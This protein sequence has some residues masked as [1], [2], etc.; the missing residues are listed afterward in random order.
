MHRRYLQ[1]WRVLILP[2]FLINIVCQYLLQDVRLCASSLT[3]LSSSPFVEVLLPSISRIVPSILQGGLLKFS[4]SSEIIK[5]KSSSLL[6]PGI[7]GV[8]FQY[9]Q[10]LVS[11]H[12]I[13]GSDSFMA[14][15][16]DICLSRFSLLALHIFLAKFQSLDGLHS[17]F[18]FQVL[19]SQYLSFG[20]CTECTNYHIYQL[21]RS[22]RIWYKVNF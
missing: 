1:C 10:I 5:K 12:F 9:S 18:Y 17:S 3:F 21:L 11:F 7:D 13:E 20:L 16:S 6:S 8:F 4:R 19:Q 14:I 2:F 15:A 22:G